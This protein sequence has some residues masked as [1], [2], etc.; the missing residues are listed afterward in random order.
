MPLYMDRHDL[1]DTVNAE[2]VAQIHQEDLK[3]EH[4]FGCK[5]LTYWFDQDRRT[6]FC[7][8]KAPSKKVGNKRRAS[9]CARM[10]GMKKKL[11]SAKTARDPNSRIN[12]AL[13]AWNC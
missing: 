5:G 7:L 10:K 11:T 1:D 8:I 13:R 9:F 3:I 4:E 12:K 2:H 6:A